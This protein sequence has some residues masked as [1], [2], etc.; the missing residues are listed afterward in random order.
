MEITYNGLQ[1]M[2]LSYEST[3]A[4]LKRRNEPWF[5]AQPIE[6]YAAERIDMM[7]TAFFLNILLL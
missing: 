3:C 7:T 2:I 4:M 5:S 6:R 1:K